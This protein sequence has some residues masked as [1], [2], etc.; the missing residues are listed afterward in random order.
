MDQD[1]ITSKELEGFK[2]LSKDYQLADV[3]RL[4]ERGEIQEICN[5][6]EK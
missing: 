1:N 4:M 3:D 6:S 2:K 5:E